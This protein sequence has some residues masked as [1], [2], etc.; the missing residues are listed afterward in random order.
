MDA[1]VTLQLSRLLKRLQDLLPEPLPEPFDSGWY[2][3]THTDF[4]IG[5]L[6]NVSYARTTEL[7]RLC[8][9]DEEI[10]QLRTNTRCLL[11]GKTANNVLLTGPR[12][13]GKTTLMREVLNEFIADK[14]RVVTLNRRYL[15]DLPALIEALRR[16]MIVR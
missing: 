14:L 8:G 9:L 11:K 6:R 16:K 1:A 13:C 5:H 4:S 10:R 7:N 2:R 3:W 12:G 15:Q